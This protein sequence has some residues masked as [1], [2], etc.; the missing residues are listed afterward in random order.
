F[1]G[2][3]AAVVPLERWLP[4]ET[5]QQIAFENGLSETAFFVPTAVPRRFQLRWFSPPLEVDICGHA[6][7]ATAHVIFHERGENA[8]EV[9]FESRS[10]LLGVTRRADGKLEL[11]FPVTP[12]TLETDPAV[13]AAVTAALGQPPQWLGRSRFDLFAVLANSE[14]VRTLKPDLARV[15]AL[16]HRGL[17]VT[18]R[19]G[20]DCDFVSRFFAPQ[21][22]IPEDPATGSAH[23]ALMPYWAAELGRAQLHAR[24]LSARS[25]ELWCELA[26]NR[27]KIA[28][29]S[30]LY[31][32]GE[33]RL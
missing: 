18:A 5:M 32:R 31:L 8:A 19:G 10:G 14:A 11:D 7:L 9:S 26:G 22:G 20:S 6:T 2:N 16:G 27:V 21:T 30:V 23:C 33:I 25:A 17:I 28:G 24:Q 4:D 1:A 13:F 12:A 29:N 15:A 3:P